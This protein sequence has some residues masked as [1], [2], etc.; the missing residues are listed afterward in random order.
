MQKRFH[1]F[2]FFIVQSIFTTVVEIYCTEPPF[3]SEWKRKFTAVLCLIKDNARKSFFFKAY[4]FTGLLWEQELYRNMDYIRT[5]VFLHVF[6]GT[7][8]TASKHEKWNNKLRNNF[9]NQMV[10]FNFPHT[11]EADELYGI[12][13]EKIHA[14]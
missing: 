2:W 4:S 5:K 3:H 12:V 9:Q 1:S 10:A 8:R 13:R 7:V 14:I 6:E 11:G